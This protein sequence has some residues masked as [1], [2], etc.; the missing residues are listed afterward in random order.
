[1][2]LVS[3]IFFSY[4]RFPEAAIPVIRALPLTALNDALRAVMLDGAALGSLGVELLTLSAYALV[5]SVLAL[6]WF[7]WT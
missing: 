4:E 3:G 5:T 1:M 7:R 2:W 6:E